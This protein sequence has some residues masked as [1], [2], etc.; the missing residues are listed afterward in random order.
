M[1]TFSIKEKF[2]ES[3]KQIWNDSKYDN[4]QIKQ[5]GYASQDEIEKDALMFVG[6]NPSNSDKNNWKYRN[7]L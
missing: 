7:K 5:Y 4:I 1:A 3:I 6:I 2:E